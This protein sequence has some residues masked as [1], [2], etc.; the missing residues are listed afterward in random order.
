MSEA[1]GLRRAGDMAGAVAKLNTALDILPA[2][3]RVLFEMA[4][5]YEAMGMTE[6]SAENYR[7]VADMGAER[8]GALY[9]I[10]E[11]RLRE[12]AAIPG[13]DSPADDPLFLGTIEEIRR[14]GDDGLD[15]TLRLDI[16]ARPGIAIDAAK[17][18]VPV[19]FFDQIGSK[20]IP[21]PAEPANVD[22]T[23]APVDWK[24]PGIETVE[25]TYHLPDQPAVDSAAP[26]ERKYLG[27]SVE[28]Y[29]HDALLDVLARPRRLARFQVARD[30]A[31]PESPGLPDSLPE[32]L[33]DSLGGPLLDDAPDQP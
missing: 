9:P 32:S 3:P 12:G 2:H 5:T 27:Y 29:Y 25:I 14:P 7:T 20:V 15:I 16:H 19:Q 33:P 26:G 30:P 22:W 8:A 1:I 4:A 13:K 28:L 24:E 11:H 31:P 6:K 10:A 23:T 18:L 21:N 17:V